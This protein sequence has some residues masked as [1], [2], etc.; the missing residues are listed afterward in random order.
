[1][2]HPI[3][4][5]ER[6]SGR[7]MDLPSSDPQEGEPQAAGGRRGLPSSTHNHLAPCSAASLTPPPST[8]DSESTTSPCTFTSDLHPTYSP[9]LLCSS[10]STMSE[11]PTSLPPPPSPSSTSPIDDKPSSAKPKSTPWYRKKSAAP[12]GADPKAGVVGG[13]Q[14]EVAIE[15]D[16]GEGTPDKPKAVAFRQLFRF[17]TKGELAL[18]FLGLVMAGE[19]YPDRRVS[20]LSVKGGGSG[21]GSRKE[22]ERARGCRRHLACTPNPD[23]NSFR[24]PKDD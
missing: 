14:G 7:V 5:L 12:A 21:T 18:N 4:S 19:Y 10:P 17:A 15:V 13:G 9:F 1:M 2:S 24:P 23:N 3:R 20:Y 16:G 6:K 22:E 8:R 11:K